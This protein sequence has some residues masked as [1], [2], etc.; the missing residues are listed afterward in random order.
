MVEFAMFLPVLVLTIAG[1]LDLGRAFYSLITIS[2]AAREGARYGVMNHSDTG[3][4]I[5]AAAVQEAESSGITLSLANVVPTCPPYDTLPPCQRFNPIKVTVNY[6]YDDMIFAFF[7]PD[8]I[9]M[10][11]SVEMLVP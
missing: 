6:T 10:E 9:T 1:I 7:F 5:K 3:T 4:G 2:N 8:G 11:R